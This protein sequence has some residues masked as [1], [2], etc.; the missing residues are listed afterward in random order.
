MSG[1]AANT[2]IDPIHWGFHSTQFAVHWLSV[3]LWRNPALMAQS[4]NQIAGGS[5]N[6]LAVAISDDQHAAALQLCV[7]LQRNSGGGQLCVLRETLDARVLL[8][9]V[10]DDARQVHRWVELWVQDI[11]GFTQTPA[12]SRGMSNNHILDQQ[13]KRRCAAISASGETDVIRGA[14]E[15]V[16]PMPVVID[17]KSGMA[18]H[19]VND[20]S[21]DRWTLCEDDDLLTQHGLPPYSTSLHRYLVAK[22]NTGPA[23]VPLASDAPTCDAAVSLEVMLAGRLPLNVGGGLMMVRTHEPLSYEQFVDLLSGV[24]LAQHATAA[25]FNGQLSV[26][27]RS[28][29]E[30]ARDSGRLFLGRHGRSARLLETFH[31]KLRAITDAVA[32]VQQFVKTT[33]A[34]LLD[35]RS[36]SFRVRIGSGG[37]G[38][39]ALWVARTVLADPAEAVQ[40][41]FEA[42]AHQYFLPR[43]AG[44][45]I[46]KVAATTRTV[47]GRGSMRLRQVIDDGEG[48]HILEGTFA[49]QERIDPASGDLLWMRLPLGSTRMD[50]HATL[51]AESAL[52]A[53]EWRFRTHVRKFNEVQRQMLRQMEGVPV[54]NVL[55]DLVP[56][57]STPCDLYS[58]AVLAVRTLLFDGE[59]TLAVALDEIHSLARQLAA[60]HDESVGINLRLRTIFESDE[61]WMTGI[62]PQRLVRDQLTPAEAA[63][64]VPMELWFGV[65]SV[66]VRALPG[67]GPDSFCRNL[68]DV[69]PGAL[70]GAFDAMIEELELLIERTRCLVTAD[71]RANREVHFVAQQLGA[72]GGH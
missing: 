24:E 10:I 30:S 42:T 68:G 15:R 36:D 9:C 31:L 66:I 8:G 16:H 39:P 17:A 3:G 65:L 21:G 23:F 22:D 54:D 62:G 25:M 71:W 44:A 38:L 72:S 43:Q 26:I 69:A 14:W 60:Q 1:S 46:Y 59:T 19:P 13:W 37:R 50:V 40:V 52:A 57:L 41:P 63:D 70:H 47:Q 51:D 27:A 61:R 34:P 67:V 64:A 45:S 53:G 12:A 33:Q 49:T 5:G 29:S 35:L 4:E 32:S 7:V 56:L 48:G 6:Y 28:T 2:K 11:A 20:R 58:L 55:F 18:E